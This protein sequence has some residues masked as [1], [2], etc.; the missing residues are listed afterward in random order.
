[1]AEQLKTK[2]L[3]TAS[4][5]LAVDPAASRV[6]DGTIDGSHDDADVC[7]AKSSDAPPRCR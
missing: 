7:A 4:P 1:M 5:L 2:L 6:A 3:R